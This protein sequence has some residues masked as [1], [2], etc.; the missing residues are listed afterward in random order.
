MFGITGSASSL[1]CAARN[2]R[3][4]QMAWLAKIQKPGGRSPDFWDASEEYSKHPANKTSFEM[5]YRL[6]VYLLGFLKTLDGLRNVCRVEPL[7][8]LGASPTARHED[9]V[10]IPNGL[11]LDVEHDSNRAVINLVSPRV[12][13]HLGANEVTYPHRRDDHLFSA[14]LSV[15]SLFFHK[16]LV[17]N[18]FVGSLRKPPF[19]RTGDSSSPFAATGNTPA[20][21]WPQK[22]NLA[23]ARDKAMSPEDDTFLLAGRPGRDCPGLVKLPERLEEHF[24]LVH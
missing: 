13:L 4:I 21:P 10:F 2:R 16:A 17:S 15:A 12:R 6:F 24:H 20:G 22:Q 9:P 14:N 5:S 8:L 23:S 18:W 3:D 1:N 19:R 11:L 7:P